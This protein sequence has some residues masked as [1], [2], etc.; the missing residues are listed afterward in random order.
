MAVREKAG[1]PSPTNESSVYP[2]ISKLQDGLVFMTGQSNPELGEDVAKAYGKIIGATQ[3]IVV[4]HPTSFFEK[5]SKEIRVDIETNVRDRDVFLIQPTAY[6]AE[7]DIDINTAIMETALMADA[8]RR[9]GA[10]RVTAVLANYGYARQDRKTGKREPISAAVVAKMLAVAG[11]DMI[12]TVDLHQ[13]ASEG[14]SDKWEDLW[15]VHVFAPIIK[16]TIPGP[17]VIVGPDEGS[18]KRTRLFADKLGAP[19]A[20]AYK[21][22]DPSVPNKTTTTGLMGDVEGRVAVIVDDILA[23]GGTF[24]DTGELVLDM[25]AT[26]AYGV[27]IHG[28][29]YGKALENLSNSDIKLLHTSDSIR[30]RREVREHPKIQI[31]T[32]A[33]MIA[34]AI[35]CIQTSGSITE[36]LKQ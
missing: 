5:K 14:Y 29:F 26:E 7:A 8:A 23:S 4:Q 12:L 17:L 28:Q 35:Y 18:G 13:P 21:R 32:I 3:P 19:F 27:A 16:N 33:D 15:G 2:E 24:V 36:R 1:R 11:V 22:R 25:G 31:D 30:H 20:L 6:N 9:S 10:K 34:E